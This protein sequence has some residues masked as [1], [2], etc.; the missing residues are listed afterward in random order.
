M[1][2]PPPRVG[3]GTPDRRDADRG[4]RDA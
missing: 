1:T 3:P 2:T 4:A